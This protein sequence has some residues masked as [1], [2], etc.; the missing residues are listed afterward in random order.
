MK[1][2]AYCL[3]PT[4]RISKSICEEHGINFGDIVKIKTRDEAHLYVVTPG[5][6]TDPKIRL[7]YPRKPGKK[8]KIIKGGVVRATASCS[9]D[10]GTK[11][12]RFYNNWYCDN[13]DTFIVAVSPSLLNKFKTGSNFLQR[14]RYV[15]FGD[16][17]L[18]H[19]SDML[20]MIGGS[21]EYVMPEKGIY[22]PLKMWN[23]LKKREGIKRGSE[24]DVKP[25]RPWYMFK[26]NVKE[27]TEGIKRKQMGIYTIDM[28]CKD[29]KI[30][31]ISRKSEI[32]GRYLIIDIVCPK[33]GRKKWVR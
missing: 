8:A 11:R 21:I 12:A 15:I 4:A 24:I 14:S 29:C 20:F 9:F 25:L 31:M 10:D 7:G 33:C 28:K 17:Y 27:I 6:R 2:K 26:K 18:A 16:K 5:Y 32:K 13:V 19:K 1:F 22:F 23:V 30:P 3:R